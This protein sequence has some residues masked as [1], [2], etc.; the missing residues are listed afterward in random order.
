MSDLLKTI[1]KDIEKIKSSYPYTLKEI[2][3]SEEKTE[4]HRQELEHLLEQYNEL[5]E[6]Y[7]CV[8]EEMLR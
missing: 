3:E 5:I 8:I 7:K 4:Q 1:K 2:V 6:V